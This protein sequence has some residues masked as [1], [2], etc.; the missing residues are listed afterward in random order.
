M[1]HQVLARL[2]FVPMAVFLAVL[3]AAGCD[4]GAVRTGTGGVG[5]GGTGATPTCLVAWTGGHPGSA[6]A[7]QDRLAREPAAGGASQVQVVALL[8]EPPAGARPAQVEKVEQV[9]LVAAWVPRPRVRSR[10]I[11]SSRP[12]SLRWAS[13]P[14]CA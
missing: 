11:R 13:P 2:P 1:A 6:V 3:C 12:L 9:V 14:L 10:M 5:S 4:S 8:R 7:S